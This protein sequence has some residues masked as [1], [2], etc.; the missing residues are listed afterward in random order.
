MVADVAEEVFDAL[1][2]SFDF[3]DEFSWIHILVHDDQDFSNGF[4]NYYE[5]RVEIWASDLDFPYLR[6]THEWIKLVVTHELAHIVSLKVASK[7][8]F[9]AVIFQGGQFNRNPD[10]TLVLPWLHLVTPSWYVEGIAQLVD[11]QHV[12]PHPAAPGQFTIVLVNDLLAVGHFSAIYLPKFLSI[13]RLDVAGPKERHTAAA[14]GLG[15]LFVS[16]FRFATRNI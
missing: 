3:Y 8:I 9:N 4:A 6:G 1:A 12:E 13:S 5:N 16:G 7:G 10:F 11:D 2:S 14:L 15:D